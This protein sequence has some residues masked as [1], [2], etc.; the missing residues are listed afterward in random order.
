MKKPTLKPFKAPN[1]KIFKVQNT[2]KPKLSNANDFYYFLY[3]EDEGGDE[4]GIML[5]QHQLDSALHRAS[6]NLED[7]KEKGWITDILD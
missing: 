5:T 2:E 7:F 3:V 6:K 1:G 4:V